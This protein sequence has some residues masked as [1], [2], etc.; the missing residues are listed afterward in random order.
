M[1]C[2]KGREATLLDPIGRRVVTASAILCS[3]AHYETCIVMDAGCNV[4]S[5]V[6]PLPPH[7]GFDFFDSK[8]RPR[9]TVWD[10]NARTSSRHLTVYSKPRLSFITPPS[11]PHELNLL[12]ILT[13]PLQGHIYDR[14]SP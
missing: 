11:N 4:L 6:R 9:P 3:S 2:E 5:E 13:L 12:L 8:E 10:A 14:H 7:F 1:A